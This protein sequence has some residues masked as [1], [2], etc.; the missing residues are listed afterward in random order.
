MSLPV[1]NRVRTV[2]SVTPT[3]SEIDGIYPDI[4]K[5]YIDLHQNPE[6][7]FHETQTAAKLAARM[8]ALGF[9]VTTGV[10]RTGVV[11]I[12]EER[13]GPHRDAADRN[14]CAAGR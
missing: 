13:H 11:A 1:G 14:G 9:D 4:E 12:D 5:L 2:D 8:K 7:A 10:G 6:L 3:S